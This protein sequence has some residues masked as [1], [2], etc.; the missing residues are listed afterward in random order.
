MYIT[1]DLTTAY[2][3]SDNILVLYRGS[4]AEVGEVGDVIKNPKH[5]YTQLLIGSIPHPDPNLRWGEDG[6]SIVQSGEKA[7]SGCKFADRF[8][9]RPLWTCV[10]LTSQR[11]TSSTN[12]A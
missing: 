4:V 5:P 12:T 3:I 9:V 1:H 8:A 10:G 6:G 2:Q 7:V 11:A